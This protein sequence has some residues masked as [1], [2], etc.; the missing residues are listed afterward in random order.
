MKNSLDEKGRAYVKLRKALY[1]CIQSSKLW[2]ERL[3]VELERIGY[4][5]SPLDECIFNKMFGRFQSTL[6]VHVDDILCGC[7]NKLAHNELKSHLQKVFVDIN[8]DTGP[9]LSFL[10]MTFSMEIEGRAVVSMQRFVEEFV[11]DYPGDKIVTSPSNGDLFNIEDK[12]KLVNELE[13]KSFHTT[14]AKLLYLAKRIRPDILLTVSF[15]CTRVTKATERDVIKL[16]RLV[17]Y[18]RCTKETT[19]TL[20]VEYPIRIFCFVDASYGD[21]HDGKSHTGA[22]ITLGAGVF[23]SKS[24]KQKI[25]S[26][27][28]TEAEL[29][30]I[31]DCMGDLLFVRNLLLYQGYD[32][33]ALFLFQDNMS[34][35]ALCEKGGAGH[36]TKHIRIRNFYVKERIDD[37]EVVIRWMQ[38]EMM[39]AD[40]LTKPLQGGAF[41]KFKDLL[42]GEL[43]LD[44]LAEMA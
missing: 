12:D 41:K 43:V 14:V 42:T 38:T 21:H 22:A 44:C 6:M 18:V 33:P 24:S 29:V 37:G 11:N 13:R 3:R 35:I 31:T 39:L 19:L 8:F 16:G 27:S 23:F 5:V 20:K 17:N 40:V 2:Y 15:L 4:T 25:V 1:G 28:S 30:A 10:G 34:T 26:K 36:R 32:V 7:E 9:K